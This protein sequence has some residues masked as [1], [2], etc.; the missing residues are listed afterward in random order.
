[1]CVCAQCNPF[2]NVRPKGGDRVPWPSSAARHKSLPLAMF[3]IKRTEINSPSLRQAQ[4]DHFRQEFAGFFNS[5]VVR[6]HSGRANYAHMRSVIS[7]EDFPFD[8][9]TTFG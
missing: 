7:P 5:A 4:S 6:Q 1:V 3:R 9:A 2:E 8:D